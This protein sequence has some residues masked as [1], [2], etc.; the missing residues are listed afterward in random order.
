MGLVQAPHRALAAFRA[1]GRYSQICLAAVQLEPRFP[2]QLSPTAGN[3]KGSRG[4]G[5]RSKQHSTSGGEAA[6]QPVRNGGSVGG[7][8]A[9]PDLPSGNPP[10]A[11]AN[12]AY[13]SGVSAARCCLAWPAL[14]MPMPAAVA[15]P[16]HSPACRA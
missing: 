8:S 14:L 6:Q 7:A 15:R 4:S 1:G 9:A 16:V 3:K 12:K 5:Q 10:P 13:A 2:P 11:L